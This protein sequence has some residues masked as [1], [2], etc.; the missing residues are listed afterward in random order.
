MISAV[1]AD[2]RIRFLIAGGSAALLNWL[3][4]FP[5]SLVLPYAAA[6]LV[7]QAIGMAYGFIIYRNWAFGSSGERPIIVELRDFV[8]VNAAGAAV[9][10]AVAVAA[11]AGLLLLSVPD[12]VGAGLSHA[13]GIACGA[14]VNFLGHKH[15][16]FRTSDAQAP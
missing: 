3:V 11:K 4:R 6:L 5:L 7:A 16:T 12:M 15:M 1:L 13:V 10:V 8:A 9:T 2:Q 14:V